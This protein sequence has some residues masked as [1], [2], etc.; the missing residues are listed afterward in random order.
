M[1]KC[2]II[3]CLGFFSSFKRQIY[4]LFGL[5]YVTPPLFSI[6]FSTFLACRSCFHL[7]PRWF[8]VASP[9]TVVAFEDHEANAVELFQ[10]TV[11][12]KVKHWR[13]IGGPQ[14]FTEAQ[15]AFSDALEQIKNCSETFKGQG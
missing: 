12:D 2:S 6:S 8:A 1:D 4:S 3:V 5:S 10:V 13:P 7:L 14:N 15:T 11:Q 9:D